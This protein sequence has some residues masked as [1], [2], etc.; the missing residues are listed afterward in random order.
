MDI[1]FIGF[2]SII[3]VLS[4]F[5]AIRLYKHYKNTFYTVLFSNYFEFFYRYHFKQNASTSNWLKQELGFHKILYN[6]IVD[7]NGNAT[8]T[9]ITL[10]CNYGVFVIRDMLSFGNFNGN[11]NDHSWFIHREKNQ[12]S[13]TFKIPNPQ[14][15]LKKHIHYQEK[16]LQ[17][18]CDGIIAFPQTSDFSKAK[19]DYSMLHYGDVIS[20]IKQQPIKY[21]NDQILIAFNRISKK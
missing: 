17:L 16:Q 15:N 11:S 2:I 4:L 21:S 13:K 18:T 7:K 1:I 3:L 10:L 14:I 8:Q 9:Y 6:S 12:E 5:Q 19:S 20:Y